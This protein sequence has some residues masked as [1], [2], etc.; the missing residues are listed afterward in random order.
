[1]VSYVQDLFG[2]LGVMNMTDPE[3]LYSPRAGS[4]FEAADEMAEWAVENAELL[5]SLG[6]KGNATDEGGVFVHEPG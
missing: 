3:F 6:K 5:A 1:M 2:S 4:D